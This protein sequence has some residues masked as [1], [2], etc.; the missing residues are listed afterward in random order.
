MTPAEII[1]LAEP[2][3]SMRDTQAPM[4]RGKD[5]LVAFA[6]SVIESHE[7]QR[8]RVAYDALALSQQF[9]LAQRLVNEQQARIQPLKPYQG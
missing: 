8:W 4:I 1:A 5:D 2:F 3:L 9:Q 7:G 6:L